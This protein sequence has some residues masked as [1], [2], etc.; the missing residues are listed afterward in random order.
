MDTNKK[1]PRIKIGDIVQITSSKDASGF[2]EIEIKKGENIANT[3]RNGHTKLM[4]PYMIIIELFFSSSMTS[5]NKGLCLW[6]S[7]KENRFI[8]RWF[9]LSILKKVYIGKKLGKKIQINDAVTL[10]THMV[11]NEQI[12]KESKFNLLDE[13]GETKITIKK[14]FRN[15]SY[16]PPKLTVLDVR[17]N[18]KAINK[19]SKQNNVLFSNNIIKCIWY[20]N[21][22][23]KYS[24]LYFIPEALML[25]ENSKS[26]TR[27]YI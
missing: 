25:L 15:L 3:Y 2:T 27:N 7:N 14:T 11:N 5:Q 6:F 20:N 10:K 26:K 24:E 23:N 17:K 21:I 22:K 19:Y 1:N 18:D 4:P 9:Q 8:E 13:Y 16:S 12:Q